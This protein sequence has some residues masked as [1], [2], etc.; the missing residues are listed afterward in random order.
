MT[1]IQGRRAPESRSPWAAQ[2]V[3][4][5]VQR[6]QEQGHHPAGNSRPMMS[7]S[8]TLADVL[9]SPIGVSSLNPDGPNSTLRGNLP[10]T[11]PKG[12]PR[13]GARRQRRVRRRGRY[14]A[15]SRRW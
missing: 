2:A 7:E 5:R 8:A 14:R 9:L 3:P 13:R 6:T 4:L 15:R 11:L 1:H 10:R 12:E